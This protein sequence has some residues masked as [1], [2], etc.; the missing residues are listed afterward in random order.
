MVPGETSETAPLVTRHTLAEAEGRSRPHVL[1]VDDNTV[2]QRLAVLMLERLG[3]RVDVASDGLEAVEA[4][5]RTDYAAVLMDCQMPGMDGYEATREARRRLGGRRLPIIAMTASVMKE[6]QE[7]CAAA[8][9]DDFFSKPATL[10]GLAG[11][12]EHWIGSD[13]TSPRSVAAD[14]QP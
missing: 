1:V 14:R 6:D 4:I 11:L 12:L 2:N 7:R 3:Y 8:G 10:E 9:M 5:D 13:E